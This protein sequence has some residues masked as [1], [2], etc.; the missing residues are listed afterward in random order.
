MEV[1]VRGEGECI[2]VNVE[3]MRRWGW[4]CG[5]V[6]LYRAGRWGNVTSFIMCFR[7]KPSQFYMSF[8]CRWCSSYDD[9]FDSNFDGSYKEHYLWFTYDAGHHGG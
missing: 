3:R 8:C 1:L 6:R 7:D 9:K 5:R 4:G 2:G